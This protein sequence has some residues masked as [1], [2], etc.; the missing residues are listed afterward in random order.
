MSNSEQTQ[1]QIQAPINTPRS[2][3]RQQHHIPNKSFVMWHN[4]ENAIQSI[5]KTVWM[6]NGLAITAVKSH[7]FIS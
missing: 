7:R 5:D 4:G 1:I 3:H 2:Q 6:L